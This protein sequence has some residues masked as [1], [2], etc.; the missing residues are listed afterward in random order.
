MNLIID[1]TKLMKANYKNLLIQ[2]SYY[3]STSY[4]EKKY[5]ALYSLRQSK[6]LS[7]INIDDQQVHLKSYSHIT[8]SSRDKHSQKLQWILFQLY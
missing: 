4:L 3:L 7:I 5:V 1:K 8:L 2:C 6:P